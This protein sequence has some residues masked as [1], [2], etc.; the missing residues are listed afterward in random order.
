LAAVVVL[1]GISPW[2]KDYATV[3]IVAR[4]TFPEGLQS[5]VRRALHDD[6]AKRLTAIPPQRLK[7]IL[8][9]RSEEHTSELQSRENLVCRLLLVAVLTEI[10]TL[11][12]RRS[13][14]LLAA[15]VVLV[16]ISPWMKDYA[17]VAIVARDT[18]PEGL[19]SNVRRALHDDNAKRLT[20]IPPQRLKSILRL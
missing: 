16:G 15:V 19:Q 4:D 18:F 14:D 17:T 1:V 6:N 7:S 20:A 11:S 8:R 2:M 13:S 9:L 12:L 5:N 10:Y 3:A